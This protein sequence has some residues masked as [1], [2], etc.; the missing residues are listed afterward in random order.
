MKAILTLSLVLFFGG[1]SLA[2]D[3]K[4]NVKVATLQESVILIDSTVQTDTMDVIG[5][6]GQT[7][8]ARLYRHKNSRVKSALF[9]TTKNDTPKLA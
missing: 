1:T 3:G 7:G 8:I 2:Q 9:F 6:E 5:K 4:V